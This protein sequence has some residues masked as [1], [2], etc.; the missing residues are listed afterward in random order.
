MLTG[1]PEACTYVA[2]YVADVLAVMLWLCGPPSDQEEK[3]YCVPLRVWGVGALIVFV[4][5]RMTVRVKGA[6]ALVPLTTS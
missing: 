1:A 3:T 6:V 5:P 4:E 2:L